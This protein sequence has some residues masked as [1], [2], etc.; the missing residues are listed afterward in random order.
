MDK[1]VLAIAVFVVAVVGSDVTRIDP[2]DHKPPG[3]EEVSLNDL[4]SQ[5]KAV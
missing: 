5:W 1:I 4:L 2:D 3:D